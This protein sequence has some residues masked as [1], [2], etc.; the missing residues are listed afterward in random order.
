M[1]SYKGYMIAISQEI[2][3]H[4]LNIMPNKGRLRAGG[5]GATEDVGWDGWMASP[6]QWTWVWA[7][8]G[9]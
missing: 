4:C 1:L 3:F 2:C 5:E 9:R 7:N 8:S 6:T